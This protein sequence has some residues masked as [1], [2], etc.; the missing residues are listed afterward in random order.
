MRAP[1]SNQ[2]RDFEEHPT[3]W[4]LVVCTR[5]IDKGTHWN[6]RKQKDEHRIMIGFESEKLMTEGDFKDQPFLLFANFNYSMF[7][8]AHLCRF[9]ENWRGRRFESQTQADLFDLSKLLGQKAFVNVT[10][11]HDGQYTNIE[12][13]GPVPD[14]MTAPDIKGITILIDQENFDENEYNK[15]SDKLK[16]TVMSAQERMRAEPAQAK[17]ASDFAQQAREKIENAGSY[18]E[19]FDDDIPF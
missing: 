6:D 7:K 5:V 14:N 15:L 18:P 13:I 2:S 8:N 3:G 1:Q 17:N 12:T 4:T 9:I 11:S 16:K 19:D 10:R